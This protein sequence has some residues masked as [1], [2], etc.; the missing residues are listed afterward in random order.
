MSKPTRI[1]TAALEA[2]KK[3]QEDPSSRHQLNFNS[4]LNLLSQLVECFAHPA[5]VIDALDE[6]S[7][8]VRSQLLQGLLSVIKKAKCPFKVFVASRH[9]LEIE[10]YLQ[11]LP[12]VCIEARDN[13]QD[14]QNYVQQELSL[15]IQHKRLLRGNVSQ[16]LRKCMEE[17]I[18]RDANGM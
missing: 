16:D 18:L 4:S 10:N 8:E 11:D 13:A 2:Y 9:N 6:C 12:H 15:G 5:V 14:I 3:E 17:I 1:C 7:E